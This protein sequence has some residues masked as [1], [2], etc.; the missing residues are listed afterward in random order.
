MWLHK[1]RSGFDCN[2]MAV[3]LW[4]RVGDVGGCWLEGGRMNHEPRDRV[5]SRRPHRK[6]EKWNFLWPCCRGAYSC[7]LFDF[8]HVVPCLTS[9]RDTPLVFQPE[10]LRQNV[11]AALESKCNEGEI[12]EDIQ[13]RNSWKWMHWARDLDRWDFIVANFNCPYASRGDC[14]QEL[15]PWIPTTSGDACAPCE[16]QMTLVLNSYTSSCML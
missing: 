3:W 13:V 2:S 16:K 15:L 10:T 8:C 14:C 6:T 4:K 5:A 1:K 11:L 7:W 12:H 9:V